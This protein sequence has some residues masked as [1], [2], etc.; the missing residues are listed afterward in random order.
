MSDF[1]TDGVDKIGLKVE[2]EQL[3]ITQVS[4]DSVISFGADSLTLTG[5]DSS[6]L[7]GEDFVSVI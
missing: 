1:V 4:G 6:L 2:F 5:V 7:T 3:T